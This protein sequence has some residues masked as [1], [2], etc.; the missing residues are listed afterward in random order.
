MKCSC[1]KPGVVDDFAPWRPPIC[2]E[3]ADAEPVSAVLALAQH[4][5][6]DFRTALADL[7]APHRAWADNESQRL[8]R[9]ADEAARR[10]D[11]DEAKLLLGFAA[12]PKWKSV[13]DCWTAYLAAIGVRV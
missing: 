9:D 4:N 7:A 5:A 11:L 6:E 13:A 3:C 12:T 2:R 1:G 10:G 8:I